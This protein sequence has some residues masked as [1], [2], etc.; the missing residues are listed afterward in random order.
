VFLAGPKG[1]KL[2]HLLGPSGSSVAEITELTGVSK[3]T[4]KRRLKE[5]GSSEG[6][7]KVK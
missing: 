6:I 3:A 7:V 4:L 2:P 1:R 5:Q